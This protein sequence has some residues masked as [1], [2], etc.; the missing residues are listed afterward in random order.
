MAEAIFFNS[1]FGVEG[2]E[3]VVINAANFSDDTDT[4][5]AISGTIAGACLGQGQIHKQWRKGIEL[6]DYLHDLAERIWKASETVDSNVLQP[7]DAVNM[8]D[9]EVAD[10]LIGMTDTDDNR[11]FDDDDD[12]LLNAVGGDEEDFEVEF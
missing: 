10:D 12:N 4:I 7:K 11:T 6:S 9:P 2:F 5:A 1:R 8:V 3:S